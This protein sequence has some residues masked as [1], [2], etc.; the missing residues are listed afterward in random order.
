MVIDAGIDNVKTTV[1][2]NRNTRLVFSATLNSAADTLFSCDFVDFASSI[3]SGDDW[4]RL[5]HADSN[6]VGEVLEVLAR[7]PSIQLHMGSSYFVTSTTGELQ[8]NDNL[9]W[10]LVAEPPPRGSEDLRHIGEMP[11]LR[12]P[13]VVPSLS[14]TT[15][16]TRGWDKRDWNTRDGCKRDGKRFHSIRRSSESQR[17]RR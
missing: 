9:F 7:C 5:R 6:A 15:W 3:S 4:G 1:L 13:P 17:Q 8:G 12:S 11:S 10:P 16:N 14:S 2:P